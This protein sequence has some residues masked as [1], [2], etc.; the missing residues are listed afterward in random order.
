MAAQDEQEPVADLV[1]MSPGKNLAQRSWRDLPDTMAEW[2]DT[3]E[4]ADSAV[5]RVRVAEKRSSEAQQRLREVEARLGQEITGLQVRLRAAEQTVERL[6]AARWQAEAQ[7]RASIERAD[8]A[9][10]YLMRI[11]EVMRPIPRD[12]PPGREP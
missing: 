10:K 8:N 4:L 2:T 9:E 3:V 12:V 6:E 7:V 11:T 5:E 1:L